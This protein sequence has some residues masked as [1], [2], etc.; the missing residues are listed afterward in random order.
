MRGDVRCPCLIWTGHRHLHAAA[1]YELLFLLRCGSAL[2]AWGL[3]F[4]RM[5]RNPCAWN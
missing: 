2:H 5:T 4:A 3:C 1:T